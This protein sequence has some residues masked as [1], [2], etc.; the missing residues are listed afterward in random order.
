MASGALHKQGSK[1]QPDGWEGGGVVIL[2]VLGRDF[3]DGALGPTTLSHCRRAAEEYKRLKEEGL[4][5]EVWVT[6]GWADFSGDNVPIFMAE[7]MKIALFGQ[8]VDEGQ[9]RVLWSGMNTLGEVDALLEAVSSDPRARDFRPVACW[10]HV[11]V[12]RICYAICGRATKGISAGRRWGDVPGEFAKL[13]IYLLYPNSASWR[14][15]SLKA[16]YKEDKSEGMGM[17][18]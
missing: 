11:W 12:A 17:E 9:I 14:L 18:E 4:K 6:T 2:H 13:L 15:R 7:Q 3:K 16:S 10:P 8:G 5:V 1:L